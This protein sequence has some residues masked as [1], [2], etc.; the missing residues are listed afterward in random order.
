MLPDAPHAAQTSGPLA[1]IAWTT[2]T[3]VPHDSHR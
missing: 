1:V 2:S 3:A